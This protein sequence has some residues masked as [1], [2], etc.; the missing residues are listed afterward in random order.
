MRTLKLFNRLGDTKGVTTLVRRVHLRW[1]HFL[2]ILHLCACLTSLIG[3]VIPSLQYWGIAWTFILILDLPISLVF[4]GLAWQHG[5]LAATWIFVVGTC[6]WYLLSRGAEFLID[7]MGRRKPITLF[8][9][10]R[11]QDKL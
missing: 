5:A 9:T 7:S 3:F 4:Y 1:V 8:F 10:K 2:P 6:W 11:S